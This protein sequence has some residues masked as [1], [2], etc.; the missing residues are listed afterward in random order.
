MAKFD[1]RSVPH[2][3][4]EFSPVDFVRDPEVGILE[5]TPWWLISAALHAVLLLAAALVYVERFVPVDG[6]T[7]VIHVRTATPK[8]VVP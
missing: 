8:F 4:Q 6:G 7:V 3:D 2:P 1:P 5:N